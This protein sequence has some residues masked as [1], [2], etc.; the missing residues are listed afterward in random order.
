MEVVLA[1][2]TQT[3]RFVLLLFAL[4]MT[5]KPILFA[6]VAIAQF[7]P[8]RTAP[9]IAARMVP[10]LTRVPPIL[11]ATPKTTLGVT[12]LHARTKSTTVALAMQTKNA[13]QTNVSMVFAVKIPVVTIAGLA[14]LT[15]LGTQVG[16]VGPFS[17]GLTQTETARMEERRVAATMA[18]AMVR[19]LVGST[20]KEPFAPE[21]PALTV[22]PEMHPPA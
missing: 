17:T 9:F 3:I 4:E 8:F 20:Q 15:L 22:M 16:C 7:H 6:K 1:S 13:H 19:V 12:T 21:L 2:H 5:Y 18:S 10:A 11:S 14:R